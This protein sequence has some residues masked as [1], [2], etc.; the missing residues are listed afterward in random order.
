MFLN[1]SLPKSS[2]SLVSDFVFS[3]ASSG[4]IGG[5]GPDGFFSSVAGG[6]SGAA[7]LLSLLRN[8]LNQPLVRLILRES[9]TLAPPRLGGRVLLLPSSPSTYAA[10]R[11]E[12]LKRRRMLPGLVDKV[13]DAGLSSAGRLTPAV[14]VETL[15]KTPSSLPLGFL[16]PSSL[17]VSG[18]VGPASSCI[19]DGK[20]AGMFVPSVKEPNLNSNAGS[21]KRALAALLTGFVDSVFDAI[22]ASCGKGLVWRCC[23]MPPNLIVIESWCWN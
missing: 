9:A 4:I 19:G 7:C 14:V 17:G 12:R 13:G 6:E 1:K 2:S 11:S 16:F 20:G 3:A 8:L 23:G 10:F 22:V 21:S 15:G 18:G 5:G